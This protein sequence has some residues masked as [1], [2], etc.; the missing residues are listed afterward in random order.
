MSNEKPLDPSG[1]REIHLLP[2]LPSAWQA[3]TVRG[4]CARGGFEVDLKWE[5]GTLGRA[6]IRSKLNQA[7]KLRYRDRTLELVTEA[8]KE[9]VLSGALRKPG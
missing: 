3:G 8:G 4:L 7:A 5:R 9:Y 2:A 1:M 6:V